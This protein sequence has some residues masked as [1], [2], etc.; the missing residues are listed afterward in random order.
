MT[1]EIKPSTESLIPPQP[2]PAGAEAFSERMHGLV[3]GQPKDDA[4]ISKALEGMDDIVESIAAGL[5]NLASMLVGEGEDAMGLVETT[6]ATTEV[7]LCH[8]PAEGSRSSRRALCT[9]AL[10]VIERRDPGSLAAP[11]GSSTGGNLH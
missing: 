1:E 2:I 7:S 4:A 6:I 5:Y 8:D 10:G 9:A 11:H 3:D